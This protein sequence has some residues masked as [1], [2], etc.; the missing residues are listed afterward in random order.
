MLLRRGTL[1]DTAALQEL[2]TA[3]R[4]RYVDLETLA[5]VAAAPAIAADRLQAGHVII[6]EELDRL[7]GF[8]LTYLVDAQLYI[9]NISVAPGASG[10]GIGDALMRSAM[11]R[12]GALGLGALTLTTFRAPRWNAPWFG[13]H[14]FTP[15]PDEAV[16]PGLREILQ[17]QARTVD[18][19]TRVALWRRT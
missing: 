10:Q 18:P 19:A 1:A 11:Q 13:R 16:G 7:V 6:A 5:F 8:V 4:T 15:I 9:A 3:A 14:G 12:A 17:R 2:E